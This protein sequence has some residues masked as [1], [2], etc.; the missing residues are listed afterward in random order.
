MFRARAKSFVLFLIKEAT[1]SGIFLL[2]FEFNPKI[3]TEIAIRTQTLLQIQF[4]H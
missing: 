4:E 2:I 3:L 1:I